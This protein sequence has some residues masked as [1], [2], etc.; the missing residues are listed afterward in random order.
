MAGEVDG[1]QGAVGLSLERSDVTVQIDCQVVP[2]VLLE[3]R[4]R[5]LY[6]ERLYLVLARRRGQDYA[7]FGLRGE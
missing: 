3:P 2:R 7:A 5:R 4:T 6:E 1:I